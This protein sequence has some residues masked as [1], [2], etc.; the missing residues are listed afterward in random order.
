[1]VYFLLFPFGTHMPRTGLLIILGE[2]TPNS[3]IIRLYSLK[4]NNAKVVDK[5]I[6]ALSHL[7]SLGPQCSAAKLT[8]WAKQSPGPFH[9]KIPY[10]SLNYLLFLIT[11]HFL[12]MGHSTY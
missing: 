2:R 5:R 12:Q 3:K 4:L 6:Q 8:D 9:L 7:I 11:K 10:C 1:M